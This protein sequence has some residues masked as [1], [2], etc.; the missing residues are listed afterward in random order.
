MRNNQVMKQNSKKNVNENFELIC[1]FKKVHEII[2]PEYMSCNHH[3]FYPTDFRSVMR[4]LYCPIQLGKIA[5][6]CCYMIP[7][8][9]ITSSVIILSGT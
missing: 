3:S 8:Q 5:P 6:F 7:I 9:R 4:S 1:K 2:I